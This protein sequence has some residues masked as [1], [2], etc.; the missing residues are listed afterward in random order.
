LALILDAIGE[1]RLVTLTGAGGVGKTRLALEAA[2]RALPAFRDGAWLCDLVPVRNFDGIVEVLAGAVGVRQQP[3]SSFLESL[4]EILRDRRASLVL[5][6]GEH[7]LDSA[8]ELVEQLLAR[9]PSMSVLATSREALAAEQAI[10]L[11]APHVARWRQAGLHEYL[12]I[13]T[14]VA[15]AVA[16][17][18]GGYA[19]SAQ[20]LH[21]VYGQAFVHTYAWDTVEKLKAALIAAQ[22][23]EATTRLMARGA[24]LSFEQAVNL[25]TELF[26]ERVE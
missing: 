13:T 5:D 24:E 4:F 17:R 8:A 19:E 9:C 11:L 12:L 22:G 20:L 6:N 15:A 7:V 1:S 10:A 25:A 3:G 23:E 16:Q 18:T 2:A 21:H 14:L 26:D